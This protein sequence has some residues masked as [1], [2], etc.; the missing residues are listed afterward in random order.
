[1]A[2]AGPDQTPFVTDTVTLDGSGS[3]DV[4]GDPLTYAWSITSQPVGSVATLSDPTAVNPTFVVDVFG[5]YVVQL[6]VNDGT[7]NSAPD[8]VTIDTLNSPPKA[9]PVLVPPPEGQV[10]FGDTAT[11]DGSGSSDVDDHP[12]TF[13]WSF[14]SRPPGSGAALSDPT[15]VF[16]EFVIDVVGTYVIQLIVNDGTVNSDPESLNIVTGNFLPSADAGPDQSPLE[17]SSVVLDGSNSSDRDDGIQS[18]SWVQTAGPRVMLSDE[19]TVQASFKTPELEDAEKI[20]IS[21]MLTVTDAGGQK[22]TDSTDITVNNFEKKNPGTSG[23]GCFIA[24]AVHGSSMDSHIMLL[25]KFRDRFL[26]INP[27]GAE[28]W[29]AAVYCL[30]PQWLTS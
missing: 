25:E 1:V 14:T 18:Y 13:Q 15:A 10:F 19:D 17:K 6:I 2:D 27:V 8:T 20:I 7:V 16:P 9:L 5:T 21:F 12:L 23:G 26:L 4:D 30:L 24:T 28:K 11:L 22:A 3:T 29:C